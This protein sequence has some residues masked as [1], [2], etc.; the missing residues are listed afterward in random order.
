MAH[1]VSFVSGI[2]QER[3]LEALRS[4]FQSA[5]Q[6]ILSQIAGAPSPTFESQYKGKPL[7]KPSETEHIPVRSPPTAYHSPSTVHSPHQQR[8]APMINGNPSAYRSEEDEN[9]ALRR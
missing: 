9:E 8:G 3:D 6:T 1:P 2:D 7:H 5:S 4:R